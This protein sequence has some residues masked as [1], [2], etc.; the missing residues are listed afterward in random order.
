[1][2]ISIR[3][4]RGSAGTSST[5]IDLFFYLSQYSPLSLR[6]ILTLVCMWGNLPFP[7]VTYPP[8]YVGHGPC[9][10]AAA[11]FDIAGPMAN[12][13]LLAVNLSID[14]SFEN[15]YFAQ[16]TVGQTR[17]TPHMKLAPHS[18]TAYELY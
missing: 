1:M 4:A 16:T 14:L 2:V 18:S 12:T 13:D 7:S 8:V 17:S 6:R 5:G 3:K 11:L 10:L 9:C 15:L